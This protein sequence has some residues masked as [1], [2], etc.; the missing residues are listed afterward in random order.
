MAASYSSSVAKA[1]AVM[2]PITASTRRPISRPGRAGVEPHRIQLENLRGVACRRRRIR[3]A[4]DTNANWLQVAVCSDGVG[5]YEEM[6]RGYSNQQQE[7][8]AS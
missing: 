7:G 2:L 3:T 6:Q 5:R 8:K 4:K 1:D